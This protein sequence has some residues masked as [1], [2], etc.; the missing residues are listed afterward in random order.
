MT[1]GDLRQHVVDVYN[2]LP[3]PPDGVRYIL[4]GVHP[5]T[6]AY[7]PAVSDIDATYLIGLLQRC[8]LSIERAVHEAHVQTQIVITDVKVN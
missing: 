3:K 8:V 1:P 6:G 4:I 2:A 7:Q 5:Q